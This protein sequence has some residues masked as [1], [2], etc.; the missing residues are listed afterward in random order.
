MRTPVT[1][2]GQ[3]AGALRW[4]GGQP[5]G[6]MKRLNTRGVVLPRQGGS[7][8]ASSLYVWTVWSVD[9]AYVCR[10]CEKLWRPCGGLGGGARS[11]GRR[12]IHSASGPYMR[13]PVTSG[14]QSAGALRWPG[15]QPPGEMKRLNTRGVVLPRQGGSAGASSLYVWTVWSVDVAYVCRACEKLWRRDGRVWCRDTRSRTCARRTLKGGKWPARWGGQRRSHRQRRSVRT[16][17]RTV[18]GV[19]TSYWGNKFPLSWNSSP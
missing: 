8:G 9:V 5:P 2:G 14:G 6:E 3:S 17:K 1:S 18:S 10:A 7:A 12:C 19:D 15:G 4:P 11:S 13:T 16:P